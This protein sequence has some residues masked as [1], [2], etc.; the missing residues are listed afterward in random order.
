M[1]VLHF[2]QTRERWDKFEVLFLK[3]LV[4]ID[5]GFKRWLNTE[6][7]VAV[8]LDLFSFKLKFIFNIYSHIS[9]AELELKLRQ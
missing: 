5:I 2:F 6:N 8:I 7:G 1:A 4:N 9:S 3:V